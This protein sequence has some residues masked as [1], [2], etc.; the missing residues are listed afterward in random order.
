MQYSIAG[1]DLAKLGQVLRRRSSAKMKSLPDAVD[2]DTSLVIGKPE[3]RVEIDR[4]RAADLGVR[5]QDIAQA[6]NILI[7]GQNV[8]DVQRRRQI[9]TTS[10]CAR[11]NRSARISTD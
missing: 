2:A 3:F 7:G 10:R 11:A 1:P 9:S 8:S 4:Q 5:V 6:L